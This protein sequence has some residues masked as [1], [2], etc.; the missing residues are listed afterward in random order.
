MIILVKKNR[1]LKMK[2]TKLFIGLIIMLI[3]TGCSDST[4]IANDNCYRKLNLENTFTEYNEKGHPLVNID[5]NKPLDPEWVQKDFQILRQILEESNPNIYR[6]NT[7]STIDSLFNKKL[8]LLKDTVSY[9]QFTQH[10]AQIFN[11]IACGH[12]GWM[13]SNAFRTYRDS[14][15][16]FFPLNIISIKNR[17]FISQ[18]NTIDSP[19]F[20]GDEIISIN[21]TTPS[22]INKSLRK[23]MYQDGESAPNSE[24]EISKY[25]CNAYSNFISNPAVFDLVIK[26][27]NGIYDSISLIAQNKT[28]ID[29][30]NQVRCVKSEKMG[31]PLRFN[32]DSLKNVATYTIKWFRNEYIAQNGQNFNSFTDSIFKVINIHQIDNLI[33]DIRGNSGGWTANGKTLFSYFIDQPTDY[34]SKVELS[35]LDTFSIQP[36][37][38]SNQGLEDT[39]QFNLNENGLYEWINYPNLLAIPKKQNR[40]KGNVYIL[41]NEGSRSCSAA[42][43]A[44]M[45]AHTKAVFI[46][47][48][49]G[50]S[51][52]GQGGMVMAAVLPYSGTIITTS[53]AKYTFNVNNLGNYRGVKVDY[54]VKPN[55]MDLSLDQE[56]KLAYELIK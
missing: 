4:Q 17:Y 6:Y 31:I 54:L 15:L 16:K 11:T 14:A 30:I 43:S 45:Q 44:L 29:S 49:N 22:K 41:I 7:K 55:N 20:I 3:I 25:F 21:G 36:F 47:E 38:L 24:A 46:G 1:L 8:C 23:H 48:E 40:F 35:R 5:F 50:G 12:S 37:I 27:E 53:T 18:N 42:F 19:V 32:L 39:M 34:I 26:N 51:Q 56:M 52:C 28:L 13:H 9:I 2:R 33:I 10:I